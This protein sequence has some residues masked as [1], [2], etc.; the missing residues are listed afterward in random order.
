MNV[1]RLLSIL[2][3]FLCLAAALYFLDWD[4][5]KIAI[6]KVN[7]WVLSLAVLISFA[8]FVIFGIRWQHIVHEVTLPVPFWQHVTDYLYGVF[9][10][11][12]T[13]ANVGGDIYRSIVLRKY[14]VFTSKIIM[15]LARDHF[16]GFFTHLLLFFLLWVCV[17]FFDSGRLV[18]SWNLFLIVATVIFVVIVLMLLS[19]FIL[20]IVRCWRWIQKNNMWVKFFTH[21]R[22]V[23]RFQSSW[24]FVRLI[25]VTSLGL[26]FWILTVYIVALDLGIELSFVTIGMISMIVEIVRMVPLTVQGIGLREGVFTHVFILLNLSPEHGFILGLISY[27]VMNISMLISGLLI[28]LPSFQV[29]HLPQRKNGPVI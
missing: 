3:T 11:T 22:E 12:F 21:L 28:L 15:L 5:L 7:P 16:L 25:G 27:I 20:D 13:P 4:Q 14:R 8:H 24:E 23:V 17:I 2:F 26:G 10:E 6:Q 19:P 18:A 9:V 29:A 1:K